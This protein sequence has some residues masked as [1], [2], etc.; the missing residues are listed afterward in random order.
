MY[1]LRIITV[2]LVTIKINAT[3]C[4]RPQKRYRALVRGVGQFA[5][6]TQCCF[7]CS[8]AKEEE[9]MKKSR[10]AKRYS[11]NT[12]I[13]YTVL[14][15]HA[16]KRGEERK[17]NKEEKPGNLIPLIPSLFSSTPGC[18]L[19]RAITEAADSSFSFLCPR[20][21]EFSALQNLGC[22]PIVYVS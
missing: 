8:H 6:C 12:I 19:G 20:F 16:K 11:N 7:Y 18:L 21:C 17:M 15:S 3:K 4:N 13:L 9:N 10:K 22:A 14:Q 2:S 5:R 1:A